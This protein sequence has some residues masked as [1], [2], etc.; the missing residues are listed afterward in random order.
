MVF[1]EVHQ[2]EGT[3]EGESKKESLL[4]FVRDEIKTRNSNPKSGYIGLS[5]TPAIS[6]IDRLFPHLHYAFLDKEQVNYD[7]IPH[8]GFF[9]QL[10]LATEQGYQPIPLHY[11]TI[12]PK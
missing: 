10:K 3:Q 1:D 8:I 4:K 9:E 2:I 12:F 5:A 6:G 7:G 11:V